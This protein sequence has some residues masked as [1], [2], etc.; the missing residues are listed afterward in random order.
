MFLFGAG[1][2][3]SWG[4]RILNIETPD[5]IKKQNAQKEI[6]LHNLNLFQTKLKDE[7]GILKYF[8]IGKIFRM[9]S[10]AFF[11]LLPLFVIISSWMKKLMN[12]INVPV[13]PVMISVFFLI[14]WIIFKIASLTLTGDDIFFW[15]F[16]EVRESSVAFFF[17]M[18]SVYFLLDSKEKTP[19]TV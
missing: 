9:F 2:E 8:T 15:T 13:S 16:S 18:A 14:N 11:L 12:D 7:K 5:I 1:E 19:Q 10:F 4:Q 17:M 6:T 3:I